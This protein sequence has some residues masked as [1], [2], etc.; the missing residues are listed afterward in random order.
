MSHNNYQRRFHEAL[1]SGICREGLE[2]AE[3][4]FRSCQFLSPEAG[5]RVG[6]FPSNADL[7]HCLAVQRASLDHLLIVLLTSKHESVI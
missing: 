7:R 6:T 3:C 5:R 2:C 1:S 4:V